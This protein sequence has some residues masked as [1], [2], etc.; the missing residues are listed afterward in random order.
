M[1]RDCPTMDGII[2]DFG[3]EMTEADQ[4]AIHEHLEHCEQCRAQF[5]RMARIVRLLSHLKPLE[6]EPELHVSDLELAAFAH[7]RFNAEDGDRIARHLASCQH[8]RQELTAVRLALDDYQHEE[9]PAISW[10]RIRQ[11]LVIAISTPARTLLLV[12][13]ALCYL[14]E[15]AAFGVALGQILLTYVIGLPGYAAVPEVWPLTALPVGVVRTWGLVVL[16]VLGG[17]LMR[18]VAARLYRRAVTLPGVS[19]GGRR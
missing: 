15:C 13:A 16:G 19:P 6:P 7:A 10:P 3:S 2:S 11:D 17:V 9:E 4:R 5:N 1:M 14:A 12:A 18:M 8:C